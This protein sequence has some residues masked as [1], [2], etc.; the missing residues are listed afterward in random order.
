[1]LRL[2][3]QICSVSPAAPHCL[4]DAAVFVRQ[5]LSCAAFLPPFAM[6]PALRHL[7][8]RRLPCRRLPCRRLPCRRLPCRRLPCRREP[9]RRVLSRREPCRRVLSRRLPCRRL[10]CRRLPCRR[11]LS[12]RLPCRRLPC[13]RCFLAVCLQPCPCRLSLSQSVASR[14]PLAARVLPNGPP[15]RPLA[16]RALRSATFR[17]SPLLL[18]QMIQFGRPAHSTVLLSVRYSVRFGA[19]FQMFVGPSPTAQFGHRNP[20]PPRVFYVLCRYS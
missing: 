15:R 7:P 14:L 10:P 16:C 19:Q 5:E 8:C 12:R 6:C 2:S 11:V 3:R 17:K 18:R 1:M 9:C 4:Y 20:F 13:R